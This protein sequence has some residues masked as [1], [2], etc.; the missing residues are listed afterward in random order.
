[1]SFE[2][3]ASEDGSYYLM[4]V[5]GNITLDLGQQIRIAVNAKA[6]GK[7]VLILV[8][9]RDASLDLSFSEYYSHYSGT[10]APYPEQ[11]RISYILNEDQYA[12]HYRDFELSRI[13]LNSKQ[14]TAKYFT[15]DE[16]AI[17]WL[18]I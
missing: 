18:L 10:G 16:E 11:S 9:M 14:I 2:L 5:H 1:M 6:K 13:M 7:A 8:D 17:K 12:K 3:T 4:T 15:D